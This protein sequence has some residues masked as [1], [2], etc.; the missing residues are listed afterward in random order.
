M[1]PQTPILL[2]S[3][4]FQVDL[5]V[6]P[7]SGVELVLGVQWL[8]TLG[9]VLTDYESLTMTFWIEGQ[10]ILLV[11]QPRPIPEEASFHQFQC[12]M[13]TNAIDTFLKVTITPESGISLE[14]EPP[15]DPR[16]LH[17]L[18]NYSSLFAVQ[19]SLPPHRLVDHHIPLLDGANPVNVRPYRYPQFQKQEIENQVCEMLKNGIIQH[20]SSAFS[21][22]LLLV[23]KKDGSWRFCVDYRAMNAITVKD[24]FPI[25]AI[26]ELLDELYGTKWFSKLDLRFGYHQ[27]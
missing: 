16:I 15:S 27:V 8:K 11:G 13:A 20:S 9:P 10:P 3:H 24:R 26:E 6:L 18:E 25:P 2:G 21:S 7:L 14:A 23:R 12:L 4:E 5:F 22:S 17:L 19:T 1:C